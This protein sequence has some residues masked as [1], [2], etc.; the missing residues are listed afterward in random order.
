[1]I[2]DEDDRFLTQREEP[3]LALVSPTLVEGGVLLNAPSLETLEVSADGGRR[4]VQVW[5]SELEAIDMGDEVAGW[6]S[7]HPP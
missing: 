4:A 3:T 7:S 6:L 5:S 1:M 2:V